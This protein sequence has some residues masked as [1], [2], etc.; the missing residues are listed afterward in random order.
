[1]FGRN[2]C[3]NSLDLFHLL[4]P[5]LNHIRVLD[6][7]TAG[8]PVFPPSAAKHLFNIHSSANS[9]HA[10]FHQRLL[11]RVRF[12][13]NSPLRT[14]EDEK[15]DLP[16]NDWYQAIF[17]RHSRRNYADRLPEE[18]KVARLEKVCRDF[19][20]FPEARAEFIRI[21]PD[22]VFRGLVGHYGRVN[23]APY[24]VAFIG[25]GSSAHFQEAV[26]Y[27]GEGIILETAA[28]ELNSCW[29]GG[30]FRPESVKKH[31]RLEG[32]EIVLAVTPVGYAVEKKGLSERSLSAFAKSHKRKPWSKLAE[33][34]IGEPWMEKALEA[35]RLS[36]SAVNRQPWRFRSEDKAISISADDSKSVSPI[37]KRLDCGIAMLHFELGAR[38]AG[39]NGRWEL[40]PPPAVAR[41]VY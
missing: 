36:P 9:F 37:S 10:S 38:A 20:P 17:K 7:A 40:L 25:D 35:A 24:Y 15:M 34:P 28:L 12:W 39:V 3:S 18:E 21:R 31:V 8:G 16:V 30:F 32:N 11:P 27:T 19:R 13:H 41:F 6:A 5:S 4:N 23:N 14:V 33:G 2:A 26:G 1:M 29:V 22:R